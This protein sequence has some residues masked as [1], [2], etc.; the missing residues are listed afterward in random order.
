MTTGQLSAPVRVP[1]LPDGRFLS[2]A[3][4][5]AAAVGYVAVGNLRLALL[6]PLLPLALYL[7]LTPGVAVV[8]GIVLLPV[9]RELV[10]SE[11]G[12]A[13]VSP[14]DSVLLLAGVGL[15][16]LLLLDED[17]R[18]RLQRIRTP[19]L[20]VVPYVA[21]L[22]VVLAAH[23]S[24]HSAFKTLT[25]L[26]ITLYPLIL[27]AVVMTPRLVPFA[28]WGFL[29]TAAALSLLWITGVG[30]PFLGNKNAAGQYFC[31]AVL[32]TVIVSRG[33]LPYLTPLPLYVLGLLYC[34]SRG[35]M[36]ATAFGAI[37][38]LAVRGLGSWR[39]TVGATVA[40]TVVVLAG[41]NAVPLTLQSKVQA[42][43]QQKD[44]SGEATSVPDPDNPNGQA[45]SSTAY[46]LR[47]RAAYRRDGRAL[48][49]AHPVVGVGVGN[50]RTGAGPTV[51]IDP[52]NVL[53]RLA[54]EGGF[55]LVLLWLVW[56]GATAVGLVRRL[57]I[58]AWAGPALALQVA[59]ITH[60]LVDVYFVRGIPVLGW[61]VVGMAFNPLFDKDREPA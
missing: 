20:F 30:G 17:W 42:V 58:N 16:P 60:G 11:G 21:W 28:F 7:L 48:A 56:V 45:I 52:H 22:L 23:L 8:L 55:P 29:V 18:S 1:R 53:I 36:V 59:S 47:I 4:L 12:A 54:A 19:L 51:S 27:G 43:F 9:L 44:G 2:F 41:Y 25:A 6:L 26:E 34:S 40:L 13:V 32:V 10:G 57:S 3:A 5:L 50:Y 35:A 31:L 15:A 14:S 33:R 49:A 38:L 61:L 46:N 24:V 39:R 37:T